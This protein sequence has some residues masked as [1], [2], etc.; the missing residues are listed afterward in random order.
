[1]T[2][3]RPISR[4]REAMAKIGLESDLKTGLRWIRDTGGAVNPAKKPEGPPALAETRNT[5]PA[6][7]DRA[8]PRH[9]S[10]TEAGPPPGPPLSAYDDAPMPTLDEYAEDMGSVDMGAGNPANGSAHSSSIVRHEDAPGADVPADT[11]VL[12]YDPK[13][14]RFAWRSFAARDYRG[15]GLAGKAPL[16]LAERIGGPGA[17]FAAWAASM[18]ATPSVW[19]RMMARLDHCS[20]ASQKTMLRVL[21]AW[22]AEIGP[23]WVALEERVAILERDMGLSY[24]Q[25]QAALL[26]V[27]MLIAWP[28]FRA[29]YTIE[30]DQGKGAF[31][32][33]DKHGKHGL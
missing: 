26:L 8:L 3:D 7:R 1:M 17:A 28:C 21:D 24:E 10:T 20:P 23:D 12:R 25:V 19:R 11:L 18:E 5:H 15:E 33:F 2:D 4:L 27:E 31:D 22:T 16:A 6:Y 14:P 32:G 30:A 29:A 13:D 9:P